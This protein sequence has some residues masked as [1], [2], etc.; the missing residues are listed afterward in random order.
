MSIRTWLIERLG[1][2]PAEEAEQRG[3]FEVYLEAFRSNVEN[4][5]TYRHA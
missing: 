4:A 3:G 1:A 2:I 5:G